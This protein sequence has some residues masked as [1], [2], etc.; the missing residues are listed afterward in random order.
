VDIATANKDG[1]AGT[2]SLRTLGTGSQQAMPGDAT[3]GGPPTGSAGGHLTG[4]YPNPSIAGNAVDSGK[5]ADHSLTTADY[6]VAAGTV[7]DGGLTIAAQACDLS[8]ATVTGVLSTDKIALTAPSNNP[9]KIVYF[10]QADANPDKV[11]VRRCNIGTAD[12]VVPA[13]NVQYVVFR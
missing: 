8:T 9:D 3:P 7:L 6:S 4:T 5:V 11:E 2:P 10:A 13:G 1:T 12:V